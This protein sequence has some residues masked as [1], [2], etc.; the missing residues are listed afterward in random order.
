MTIYTTKNCSI[1]KVFIKMVNEKKL[2]YVEIW[3]EETLINKGFTTVPVVEV[4]GKIMN[5][6]EAFEWLKTK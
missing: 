5:S 2:P 1:C 3:D 6:I 4:D